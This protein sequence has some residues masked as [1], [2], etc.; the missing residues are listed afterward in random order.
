MQTTFTID[1]Q[2][3]GL[4]EFTAAVA[5][6]LDGSGD[7]LLT[8]FV[9]H[10]SCSILVQENADPEVRD[11]LQ[12]WLG[13]QVPKSSDPSMAY[14]THTYEGPDD[15]P[16]HIRAAILPVSIQIPVAKGRMRL[17]TWQG[18]YLWE[19]RDRPHSREVA[20]HFAGG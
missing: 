6:W 7:G 18:I 4:T 5:R 20:A 2:G 15:M 12:A 13:R 1:T 10:T 17:G 11:D 3:P 19:H 8:L 14:L 16:G 9:R